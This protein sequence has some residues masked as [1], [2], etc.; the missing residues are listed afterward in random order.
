MQ[1]RFLIFLAL[2]FI[3]ITSHAINHLDQYNIAKAYFDSGQYDAARY[4]FEF[5]LADKNIS[6]DTSN[7]INNYLTEIRFRKK[8]DIEFGIG[9]IPD[10]S[11]NYTPSNR[12]EC[13]NTPTGPLCQELESTSSDIGLNINGA[14]NYYS[15]IYKNIG[16][17]TTVG[18]AILNTSHDIPT[19]YSLHFAIGPRYIFS[20]GDISIQPSFGTRFYNDNF[21]TFSYGLRINSMTHVTNKIFIDTGLDIQRTEYHNDIINSALRGHD[22]TLYLHP[23]YYINTR[24]FLSITTTISHNHTHLSALGA[25]TGRIAL[26]YFY[27]F[28]YGF[29]FYINAMYAHNSYRST[30]TFIIDDEFHHTT[31]HDNIWQFYTRIY[32]SYFNFHNF[33]PALSYT[34]TTCDS[35][36]PTYD[37]SKHQITIEIVRQF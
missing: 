19:D 9:A 14:V 15:N 33:I 2:F 24:S 13:T 18:G 32:N 31:R 22:W 1:I 35:N 17:R 10:A 37:Q 16:L 8:W 5:A 4:H 6:T 21:Y 12:H 3:P 25:N 26:G 29:N 27:I 7:D 23:K 30:G 20:Y 34:Y 36:I 28:P 11:I